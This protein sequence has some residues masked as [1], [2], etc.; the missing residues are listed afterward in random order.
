[1][2]GPYKKVVASTLRE[3]RGLLPLATQGAIDEILYGIPCPP[4]ALPQLHTYAQSSPAKILLMIDN[5]SHVQ[6]LESFAASNPTVKPWQVFIKIDEG[7]S[8]AG[9]ALSDSDY[10]KELISLTEKSKAVELKGI[11]CHAGR[12]YS[13]CGE[14]AVGKVL[15]GEVEALLTAVKLVSPEALKERK[16][17]LILSLGSTPTAHTISTLTDPQNGQLPLNCELE[18]HGGN[19]PCNDLQQLGT[20]CIQ[21]EDM[22][23]R[24]IAS[25]C[26]FYPSR[27]EALVNAGVV[28]LSRETGQIAGFGRVCDIINEKG[29]AVGDA[30]KAESK[31]WIVARLSQEHGIV[32]WAKDVPGEQQVTGTF[33]V[34]DKV[35]LQIQHA[36]ITA[37]GFGW[38]FIADKR[39][40]IIDVWVPWK[41]W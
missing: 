7:S 25:V 39:D 40:I 22:A 30:G 10:L 8:R 2:L 24:V 31:G 12:S 28:A 6:A 38:Y 34:G 41:G 17:P 20:G 21:E 1:M 9:I 13:C 4:S 11:Y 5:A 35:L 19:F 16:E 29:E 33:N 32:G 36:C 23:M 3:I 18:L 14:E 26:S 15:S 27:N 37:A